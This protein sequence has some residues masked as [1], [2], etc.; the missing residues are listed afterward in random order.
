MISDPR[1]FSCYLKTALIFAVAFLSIPCTEVSFAKELRNPTVGVMGRIEQIVL[2]GTELQA[3]PLTDSRIPIVLRIDRSYPHGDAWRYDL[4]FYGLDPGKYDL[5]DYLQRIDGSATD[6]LPEIP[7]EILSVLPEGQVLPH[8]LETRRMPWLG[9]YKMFVALAIFG[10]IV[11]FCLILFAGRKSKSQLVQATPD[12]TLADYLRPRM[13]RALRGELDSKSLAEL[14]RM[15]TEFWKGR[16]SLHDCNQSEALARIKSDSEAG[17]L[18]LKMERW[19]HEPQSRAQESIES[20]LRPYREI[21]LADPPI[22][23]QSPAKP[24]EKQ[25]VVS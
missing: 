24:A 23:N 25:G 3:A 10:W 20:I 19:L 18:Y 13:E 11:V 16:L 4:E 8:E 12:M 15:L 22:Q 5:A 14:E 2:P 21:A 6:T 1:S 17:P 7:V 9:G